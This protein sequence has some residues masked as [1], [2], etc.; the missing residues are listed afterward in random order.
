MGGLHSSHSLYGERPICRQPTLSNPKLL[1]GTKR[2]QYLFNI[3]NDYF[4]GH[5]LVMNFVFRIKFAACFCSI[6]KKLVIHLECT[7]NSL[8]SKVLFEH[9]RKKFSRRHFEH[10]EFRL[11]NTFF[12]K[13][14]FY[15]FFFYFNFNIFMFI[16]GRRKIHVFFYTRR[17][18]ISIVNSMFMTIITLQIIYFITVSIGLH[19]CTIFLQ[20]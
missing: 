8:T 10:C 4:F 13:Q 19:N 3:T 12:S 9:G 2:S 5:V 20:L 17:K 14:Y 18:S 1:G 16:F 7:P 11:H 6:K 15:L